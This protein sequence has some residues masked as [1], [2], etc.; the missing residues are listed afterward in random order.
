VPALPPPVS[1]LPPVLTR[2]PVIVGRPPVVSR[3]PMRA[4]PTPL[5]P[6]R[7]PTPGPGLLARLPR[8]T[9]PALYGLGQPYADAGRS[10]IF[11][12]PNCPQNGVPWAPSPYS[13]PVTMPQPCPPQRC[14]PPCPPRMGNRRPIYV[15]PPTPCPPMA[16]ANGACPPRTQIFVPQPAPCPPGVG[17]FGSPDGLMGIY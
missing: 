11:R 3:P 15:P 5:T 2:P 10:G 13:S 16:R 14:G 12:T 1:I 4:V 17:F 6:V 9:M 7:P 8:M